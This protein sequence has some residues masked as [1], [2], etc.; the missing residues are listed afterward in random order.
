M[1]FI[2]T[3][4]NKSYVQYIEMCQNDLYI[5]NKSF[6][7]S[8][9]H[10]PQLFKLSIVLNSLFTLNQTNL[11]HFSIHLIHYHHFFLNFLKIFYL[12][13]QRNL[14]YSFILSNNFH[15]PPDSLNFLLLKYL[16][17]YFSHFIYTLISTNWRVLQIQKLENN[18]LLH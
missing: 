11:L 14:I 2:H 3:E 8:S 1:F 4:V 10:D 13:L 12:F 16:H 15:L 7:L 18:N 6:L 5:A 17:S 9:I